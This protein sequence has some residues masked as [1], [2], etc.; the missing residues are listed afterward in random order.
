M[1]STHT[2]HTLC[3]AEDASK[4]IE[5]TDRCIDALEPTEYGERGVT[6]GL[7]T[8]AASLATDWRG[9]PTRGVEVVLSSAAT[10]R[11]GQRLVLAATTVQK[12]F[13]FLG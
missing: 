12:G 3:S 4:S 7:A 6:I 11:T 8:S 9:V 1:P 5:A 13:K 2:R 10:R